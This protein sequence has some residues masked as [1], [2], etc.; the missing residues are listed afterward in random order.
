VTPLFELVDTPPAH[1]QHRFYEAGH[2]VPRTEMIRESLAWL[3]R[4]LGPVSATGAPSQKDST[5]LR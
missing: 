1:K 2:V 5:P 4:H 3:D